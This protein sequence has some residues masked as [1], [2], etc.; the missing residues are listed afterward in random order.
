M[1]IL[2][3]KATLKGLNKPHL[4]KL[5]LQLQLNCDIEELTSETRDIA[6]QTK[7]V[8]ADVAIIN[9][10]NEKLVTQLIETK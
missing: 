4:I 3:T 9:N 1:V 6:T 10:V 2:Q 5:L 8:D 7:K